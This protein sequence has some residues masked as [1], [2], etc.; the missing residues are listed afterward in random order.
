M[1]TA[2]KQL[3]DTRNFSGT[4]RRRGIDLSNNRVL[5]TKFAGSEQANDL[6]LPPNCGGFGRIH[7]FHRDQG[8]GW[9]F[10]PL[11]I[12]VVARFFNQNP[13]DEMKIQVFQ[14]AICSWR[15]WYCY[16]DFNLLSANK[17]YSEF[18]TAKELID[19]FEAEPSTS[20]VIDLSGGQPDLVPEW[21]LWMADE[22][23]RRDLSKSIFLWSDDNL[24]NDYL[25]RYL[26]AQD[27]E[28][29]ASRENFAR[30][31]CFKGFDEHSFSFNTRAEPALFLQQFDLMR[32]LLHTGFDAY[33]YVTLTSDDRSSIKPKMTRFIDLLQEKVGEYFP[34]RVVP[35]RIR[36]FSP[37]KLRMLDQHQRAMA[38]Q[39]EAVEAFR[40]E[41]ET[42]FTA[43]ERQR[44]IFEQCTV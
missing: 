9:P 30:V 38:V 29:L 24:S 13:P 10:N 42:R 21:S 17:T 5:I 18:K 33:G 4:L 19:L 40:E 26:P 41:I 6:S 37:T 23:E 32:R 12:D 27:L 7:H 1:T 34:L 35:L 14:N 28:R 16:V 20:A 8:P 39:D 3:I 31:G 43:L 15:C 2:L 25:W 44:P 11:P 22:L 36:T